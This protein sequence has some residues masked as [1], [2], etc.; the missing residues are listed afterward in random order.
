MRHAKLLIIIMSIVTIVSLPGCTQEKSKMAEGTFAADL[1][2]LEKYTDVVVLSD[3]SGASQVAVIP[4]M[5]AIS[6]APTET[7]G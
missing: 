2:F 1:A 4:Q 7:V 5:R 6:L 3:S